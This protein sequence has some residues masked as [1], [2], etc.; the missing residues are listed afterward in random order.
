M[1]QRDFPVF[2]II[3]DTLKVVLKIPSNKQG[4]REPV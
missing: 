1:I 3:A 2:C 4:S